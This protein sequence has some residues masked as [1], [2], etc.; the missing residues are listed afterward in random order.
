[1]LLFTNLENSCP[2][3]G[4]RL[5]ETSSSEGLGLKDAYFQILLHHD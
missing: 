4:V 1:M 3:T 2:S 5:S